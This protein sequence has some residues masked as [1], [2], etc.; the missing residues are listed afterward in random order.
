MKKFFKFGCL[1]ILAIIIIIIIIVAVSGGSDD[2][3]SSNTGEKVGENKSEET[4]EEENKTFA[5]GDTVDLNGLEV[6]IT[7]AKYI[8]AAEYVPSENGKVLQMNLEVTNNKDDKLFIDSSEFNFYDSEGN[9][10]EQYFG[11]DSL[12]LSGDLN[13]GKK[14]SGTL[15][16]DVPE[17]ETYE[18]IYEPTFSWTDEQVTWEIKP[19]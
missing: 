18:L 3:S 6:T 13:A 2:T 5:V 16:Y 7:D 10:M 15:T 14:I 4:K 12:D 17:S 9:S 11:G 8:N 1:P 19:Q